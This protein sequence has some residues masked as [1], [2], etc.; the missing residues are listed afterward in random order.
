MRPV[1]AYVRTCALATAFTLLP[2]CAW[3]Q[4]F[5]SDG[6]R[7][8]EIEISIFSQQ[9]LSTPFPEASPAPEIELRYPA[10]ITSLHTLLD[11]LAYDFAVAAE[12]RSAVA[13]FPTTRGINNERAQR[14]AESDNPEDTPALGPE[15]AIDRRG[16][17]LPD[18]ER[19]AF[20]A[21]G[22]ESASFKRHNER[23]QGAGGRR[24][25][26]HLSWRQPLLNKSQATAVAVTGGERLGDHF[27]L[28]GAVTLS[29]NGN[30]VNIDAQLWL[31]SFARLSGLG[32][33]GAEEQ[34]QWQLPL[35]PLVAADKADEDKGEEPNARQADAGR[36]LNELPANP[37]QR[38]RSSAVEYRVSE[39][40]LFR[41]QRDMISN[42]LHYLDHPALGVLVEVRPY[43]L[44]DSTG[45]SD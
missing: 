11:A 25:L 26:A 31:L 29:L 40:S 22:R 28:E 12:T 44:P 3:A 23:L 5:S 1:L 21:L 17:R 39:L 16:F 38:Q 42:E 9:E 41:Q 33:E 14:Q 35:S 4:N 2:V 10:R 8:Y 15:R 32:Q 30:R 7:W 36:W 6:N 43:L 24:L 13:N 34:L 45:A 20:F 19:D 27:E 18:P 37:G